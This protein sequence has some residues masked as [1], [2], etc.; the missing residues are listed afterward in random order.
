MGGSDEKAANQEAFDRI[1]SSVLLALAHSFRFIESWTAEDRQSFISKLLDVLDLSV[2]QH[3]EE[4][5]ESEA[6]AEEIKE[7][8]T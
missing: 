2:V 5:V 8:S 3:A 6:P 1:T 7:P 4:P